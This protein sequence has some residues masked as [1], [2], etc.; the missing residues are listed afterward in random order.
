MDPPDE[1][2]GAA[3]AVSPL[4]PAA[5]QQLDGQ[6]RMPCESSRKDIH[7]HTLVGFLQGGPRYYHSSRQ[8]AWMKIYDCPRCRHHSL[9]PTGGFLSCDQCRYAI[10]AS[11]LAMEQRLRSAQSHDLQK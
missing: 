5:F 9:V 7:I 10:T 11:A 2:S 1:A 6:E 3:Q 8:E 4:H